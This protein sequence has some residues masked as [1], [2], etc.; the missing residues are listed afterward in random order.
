M[1]AY[2]EALLARGAFS[3]YFADDVTIEVVGS[4]Q[5][6]RGRAEVEGMIRY[7][8]E[9]AFDAR[10]EVKASVATD[11]R[12]AL[13]ADFVAR[14]IAEFGGLAATGRDVRVPYSVHYDLA[15]GRIKALRVYG[16][17]GDLFQALTA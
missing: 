16:L 3:D 9:Q 8:H 13:E 14:H 5:T 10:P 17:A 15:H 6:G 1:D 7:F 2:L 11:D 12:A 4:G